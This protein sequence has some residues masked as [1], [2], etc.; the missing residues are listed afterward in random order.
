MNKLAILLL[1]GQIKDK[2]TARVTLGSK[3]LEVIPNHDVEDMDMGDADDE[4]W[5]D[6]DDDDDDDVVET[7]D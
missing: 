4:G 5:W 1:K 7:L 3:G 6:V 2:E